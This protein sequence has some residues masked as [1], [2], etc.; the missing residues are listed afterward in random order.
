[1]QGSLPTEAGVS[2]IGAPRDKSDP[3]RAAGIGI[4]RIIRE[5]DARGAAVLGACT[6]GSPGRTESYTS[7]DN[8]RAGESLMLRMVQAGLLP[9]AVIGMA[10]AGRGQEP[11]APKATSPGGNPPIA[12]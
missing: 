9:L 1:M 11:T 6:V 8:E 7:S 12:G 2:M 5:V 4:I 3:S 10:T